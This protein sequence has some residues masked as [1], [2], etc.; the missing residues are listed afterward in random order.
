MKKNI[1][2]YLIT[3]FLFGC[4]QSNQS[5]DDFIGDWIII[6]YIKPDKKQ[7]FE[8][9]LMEKVYPAIYSYR[10]SSDEVNIANKKAQR[11]NRF[12]RPIQMNEDSIWTFVFM[13]DPLVKYATTTI[14]KPLL[15][16]Y[17]EEEA[18][19]IF[20]I[21]RSCFTEKGQEGFV[22]NDLEFEGQKHNTKTRP[23]EKVLLGINYIK[24]DK[25]QQFEDVVLNE[26]IPTMFAYR[27]PSN[28]LHELNQKAMQEMRF[29]KPNAINKDSTWTFI[30]MG[31]HYV[32]DANYFIAK[33]FIQKYGEEKAGEVLREKG[34]NDSFAR[35]QLLLLVEEVDLSIFK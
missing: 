23:G 18:T 15:Q 16:K 9:L 1:I 8:D 25:N 7:T 29:L 4:S 28:E 20:D 17:G 30:F 31:D 34:W 2:L 10:D 26:V 5:N 27:D 33:P 12:F 3:L 32:E 11:Y 19:K 14:G 6:N 24:Y 35:A 22:G 21:W 13:A